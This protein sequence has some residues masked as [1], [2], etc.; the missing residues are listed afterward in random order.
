MF[1]ANSCRAV[2]FKAT[3]AV[4]MVSKT[5]RRFISATVVLSLADDQKRLDGG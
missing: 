2:W 1:D 5:T 4:A 3:V